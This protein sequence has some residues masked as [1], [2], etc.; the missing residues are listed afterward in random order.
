[1]VVNN[2]NCLYFYTGAFNFNSLKIKTL[3]EGVRTTRKFSPRACVFCAVACTFHFTFF[4]L[5]ENSYAISSKS[6]NT[7][8]EEL[9]GDLK[10]RGDFILI[11]MKDEWIMLLDRG[12]TFQRGRHSTARLAIWAQLSAPYSTAAAGSPST[13]D[14]KRTAELNTNTIHLGFLSHQ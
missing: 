5:N 3:E 8:C 7:L 10:E 4:L 1:M 12:D 6:S 9:L 13:A 14:W 2:C 11:K